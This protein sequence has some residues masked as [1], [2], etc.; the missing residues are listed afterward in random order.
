MAI[1]SSKIWQL[2]RNQ[3]S[4]AEPDTTTVFRPAS[5]LDETRPHKVANV[6]QQTRC[7]RPTLA[8]RPWLKLQVVFT[9]DRL[10][11]HRHPRLCRT[12]AWSILTRE[13]AKRKGLP[14]RHILTPY[15]NLVQRAEGNP[16]AR[17]ISCMS[18]L[19]FSPCSKAILSTSIF[20]GRDI[21][22]RRPELSARVSRLDIA[23]REL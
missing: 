23:R 18:L 16:L 12:H 4:R 11:C 22:D 5:N 1:P 15:H 21:H 19:D 10:S 2:S 14:L 6:H 17:T 20:R 8:S 3:A 13:E 9:A 7:P